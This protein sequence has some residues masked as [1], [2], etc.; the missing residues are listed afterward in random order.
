MKNKIGVGL[1]IGTASILALAPRAAFAQEGG[2]TQLEDIDV[3]GTTPIGGD[4]LNIDK[5]PGNVRSIKGDALR[6]SDY[7][8]VQEGVAQQ[9]PSLHSSDVTGNP[10]N[11]EIFFRGFQSSPTVGVPQGLAVYQ[12]GVR[13]NEALGDSVNYDLIPSVA[14]DRTDIWTNNPVFGLNALGGAISFQTKNGFT[15]QGLEFETQMGSF[16]R[17]QGSAQWGVQKGP[18]AGYIAIEGA[19]DG[20]WRDFS[21][22]NNKKVFGDVGYKSDKAEIHLNVTYADSKLGVVG[23]TPFQLLDQRR[24]AVYTGDQINENEMGM[25]NLQGKFEVTDA[26]SIQANA[27]YRKFNRD[28]VDGN[29]TDVGPCEN[30]PKFLCLEAEEFPGVDDDDRRLWV[31]DPVTGKRVRNRWF[32]NDESKFGPGS[33]PGS[34]ERSRVRADQAGGTFQATNESE[35]FG[36]KNHFVFGV[37]YDYGKTDFKGWSEICIIPGNLQCIGTGQQYYTQIPGGITPVDITGTNHYVGLYATD[38][39]DLTD[40]LSATLGARWNYAQ[41]QIADHGEL[42]PIKPN[43]QRA[44]PG[45]DGTH[46]FNRFN[47]M[48]GLTY[49]ITPDITAFGS[50]SES[51]RAPTPLELGCANPNVPCPLEATLVSDPPLKQVVTRT[52][53]AGFRG[54]HEFSGAL[55]NW[56]AAVYRAENK[57]DIVNVPSAITGRGYFVDGGKTRRQGVELSGQLSAERWAIYANY[58]YIDAT[59]R[60]G[61]RLNSNSPAAK[62]GVIQVSRGD[63]LTGIPDHQLKFGGAFKVTPKWSV[64]A[65]VLVMSGQRYVGDESNQFPKLPGYGIVNVN[66]SFQAT[67]QLRVFGGI[68]NLFDKKYA[69]YGTFFETDDIGF[70]NLT[71]PRSIT[72]ARPITFY[73]GINMK[74]AAEAAPV[75]VT[76]Y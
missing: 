20:G 18:W 27:Y 16:G 1:L 56:S 8:T 10:F 41:I 43:G 39:L 13:I 49:K 61:V 31:R 30:N 46:E 26:W 55:V 9:S 48:G 3:I 33:T 69:T 63:K 52:G 62:G 68:K 47:P 76:K 50:Y 72:P 65:D 57:N 59:F 28:G 17:Y 7:A 53:E 21:E 42:F 75:L 34:I 64:G 54:K 15:Y 44:G 11:K 36:R 70:L 23:P 66:T 32:P 12:N 2:T 14:I 73:G 4:G 35:F 60:K 37:S 51:N 74:F 19:R 5:I 6:S 24:R 29:D 67:E 45:L 71:D 25:V 58:S 38:T 22:S 40:R